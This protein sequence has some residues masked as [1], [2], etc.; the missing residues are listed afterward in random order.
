M[1]L[2]N[3]TTFAEEEI[4]EFRT[5]QFNLLRQEEAEEDELAEEKEV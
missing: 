1:T 3:E 5:E 4:S 2:L